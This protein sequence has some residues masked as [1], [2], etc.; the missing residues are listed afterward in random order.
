MMQVAACPNEIGWRNV[1]RLLVFAT[2]DGFHI[3]GDGKLG[4]ILT[5]NDGR[6]HLEDNMYKR[7]NEFVSVP[8][9]GC[10]GGGD[11]AQRLWRGHWARGVCGSA[12]GTGG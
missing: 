11:A 5:P 4:A 9:Q 7:S 2:D 10:T 6:C 3:A 1:T 12:W 8:S